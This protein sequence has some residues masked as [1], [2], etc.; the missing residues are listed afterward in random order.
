ME[1]I[2]SEAMRLDRM[3]DNL[4]PAF[5]EEAWRTW[6]PTQELAPRFV[7]QG[8]GDEI[9]LSIAAEKA[10]LHGAWTCEVDGIRE[11]SFYVVHAEYTARRVNHRQVSVNVILTW[12]DGG[13]N[14]L[15]REYIDEYTEGDNEC[16]I[17]SKLVCAP[18]SAQSVGIA[19]EFRWS[20]G[21]V[22][23]TKAS[24]SQANMVL[25]QKINLVT[26]YIWPYT[27]K[28]ERLN[29]NL[30]QMLETIECAG[31]YQPDL[32]CLSETIYDY[33]SNFG[34]ADI[35]QP[36][37]GKLSQLVCEKARQI[38]SYIVLNMYERDGEFIYNTSIL[39]DRNG[40]IAGKYRKTHLPLYEAERGVTPGAD[41]PVFDTDF[42]KVG[43]LICYDQMFPEAAR[44]LRLKGAEIICLPTAGEGKIQQLARA[45]D[46]GVY[47]VVAGINGPSRIINPIGKVLCET[48]KNED[49][50][51]AVS[52]ACAEVDLNERFYEYWLSVGAAN[53]EPRS[54][55]VKERRPDIYA[56]VS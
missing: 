52:I 18:P 51:E 5:S 22:C 19:L 48:G 39:I 12:V 37:P 31:E 55:F 27:G 14:W 4:L 26:T 46:N 56:I 20:D 40:E 29:D 36:I 16:N 34:P 53:G 8:E 3:T 35:A 28:R 7:K 47:L 25:R 30:Q 1:V 2:E 11:K 21:E 17:V 44:L 13:G 9:R 43:L 45:V 41:I 49:N 50:P 24:F 33:G 15:I 23:W 38:R 54:L 6:Q 32:L 42:G 10:H